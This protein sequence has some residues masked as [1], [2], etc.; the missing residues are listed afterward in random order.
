MLVNVVRI[1]KYLDIYLYAYLG[2]FI[3]YDGE[4]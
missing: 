4:Y 3:L 1:I 2:I